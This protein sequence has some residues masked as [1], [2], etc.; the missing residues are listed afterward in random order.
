ME[1]LWACTAER[2]RARAIAVQLEQENARLRE[3]V[4]HS[5]DLGVYGSPWDLGE[6]AWAALADTDPLREVTDD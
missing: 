5:A 4:Q 1:R 3:V 2:D 6:F